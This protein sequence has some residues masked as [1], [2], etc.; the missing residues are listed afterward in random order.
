M[1]MVSKSQKP[2]RN[3]DIVFEKLSKPRKPI[4]IYEGRIC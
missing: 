3:K 4:K 2:K 1:L